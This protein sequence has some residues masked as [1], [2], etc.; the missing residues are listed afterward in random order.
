MYK[1]MHAAYQGKEAYLARK[2]TA[3]LFSL[4]TFQCSC[5][6]TLAVY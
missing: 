6:T 2:T 4:L 5:P 3:I 1:T